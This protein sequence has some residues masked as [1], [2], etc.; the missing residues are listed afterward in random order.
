VIRLPS[1]FF[2]VIMEPDRVRFITH[3]GKPILLV[4]VSHCTAEE[5]QKISPLVPGYVTG[6][7]KQSVLLLADFTGCKIDRNAAERMKQDMVFDRPHLKRAAWVGTEAIPK[8]LFDNMKTFSR[9]EPVTFAT[10]D[11]ALDWLVQD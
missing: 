5:V 10:R 6:E 4:D 3:K 9:R 7:P 8:V 2:G 11:E 1:C